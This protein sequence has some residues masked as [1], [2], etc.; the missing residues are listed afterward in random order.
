MC[1][2]VSV[3][4]VTVTHSYIAPASSAFTAHSGA[5]LIK[6]NRRT[7]APAS[8]A[9]WPGRLPVSKYPGSVWRSV[10][11]LWLGWHCTLTIKVARV[12]IETRCF[13]AGGASS[14]TASTSRR[15]GDI[16]RH[17]PFS[18]SVHSSVRMPAIDMLKAGD[19]QHEDSSSSSTTRRPPS[20]L[21]LNEPCFLCD[22]GAQLYTITSECGFTGPMPWSLSPPTSLNPPQ[23]GSPPSLQ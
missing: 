19:Q 4:N 23:H 7:A 17:L 10:P 20:F 5:T 9:A 12:Y 6:G 3:Y 15:N 13:E 2:L 11:A 14:T 8:G 16:R 21:D 22:K 1:R 18:L